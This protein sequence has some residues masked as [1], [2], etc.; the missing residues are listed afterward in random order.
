MK[1]CVFI[2]DYARSRPDNEDVAESFLPYFALRYFPERL[3][4]ADKAAIRNA[5]PNRLAYFDEQELDLTL[6]GG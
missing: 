6:P 3:T 5:I 1:D 4:D 2:S